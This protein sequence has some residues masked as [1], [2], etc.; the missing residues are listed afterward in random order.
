MAHKCMLVTDVFDPQLMMY[1]LWRTASGSSI[2]RVPRVMSQPAA[3]AVAQM[4]RSSSEA[5]RRWK[6]RRARLPPCSLPLVPAELYGRVGFGPSAGA[7]GA[8][9]WRGAAAVAPS[10]PSPAHRPP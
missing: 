10:P 3:P 4:V 8:G 5:P 7:A 1:R 6:K 2:A 9:E